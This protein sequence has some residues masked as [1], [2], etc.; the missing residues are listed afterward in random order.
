MT[1]LA[2]V[3]A[4]LPVQTALV[5]RQK[6]KEVNCKI[7]RVVK[8]KDSRDPEAMMALREI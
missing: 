1:V 3:C 8:Q 6:K 4:N 5:V 2:R 7:H